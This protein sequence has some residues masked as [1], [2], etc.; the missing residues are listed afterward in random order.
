MKYT[1]THLLRAEDS[2]RLLPGS[3]VLTDVNA[4]RGPSSRL[5]GQKLSTRSIIPVDHTLTLTLGS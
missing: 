1:N 3:T 5:Q 4:G 2:T